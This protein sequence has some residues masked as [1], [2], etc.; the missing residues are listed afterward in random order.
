MSF[1]IA[2]SNEKETQ[3]E[4][5]FV[6]FAFHFSGELPH[7]NSLRRLTTPTC[8]PDPSMMGAPCLHS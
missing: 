2:I 6:G 7:L 5:Q 8:L 1:D 3:K 4:T